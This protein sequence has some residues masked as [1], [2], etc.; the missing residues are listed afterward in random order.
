MVHTMTAARRST[1][2]LATVAGCFSPTNIEG[3]GDGTADTTSGTE[4]TTTDPSGPT[5]PSTPTVTTDPSETAETTSATDPTDT[6]CTDDCEAEGAVCN[7]DMLESCVVGPEGCRIVE[8]TNCASGCAADAC[9]GEPADLAISIVAAVWLQ[10]DLQVTYVVANLGT[11]ASAD[12]RVD[13]WADRPGGFDGPP[14][15]GDIG[16]VGVAKP[17]LAPGDAAQFTDEVPVAP[18]GRHVAFAVI[19]PDDAVLES[20][21]NNNTSLGF[22]WTNTQ[23]EIHTSFGAPSAP[24]AI[25]DDGTPLET[26]LMVASGAVGPQTWVSLNVTHPEASDLTIEIVAP[27]GQA[28]VLASPVP[29]GAN[30][31]GTTFRDG[32][33]T[34]LADDGAPFTGEFEPAAP[35]VGLPASEGPW[36]LR[37]TDTTPGNAGRVND[38]SVSVLQ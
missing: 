4:P 19:D 24:L 10:T 22:A 9:V 32:V 31:G 16:T 15:V 18:N 28:R 5:D 37:I 35:W 14:G 2:V 8:T 36:T 7:G 30:L 6:G 20:D 21:E 23:D 13:L 33:G 11:G 26:M 29:A 3:E 25:P 38:W 12:Y 27:D 34:T 1:L 17:G